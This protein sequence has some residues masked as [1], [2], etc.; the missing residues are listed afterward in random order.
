MWH[1]WDAPIIHKSGYFSQCVK[2]CLIM[3]LNDDFDNCNPFFLMDACGLWRRV[4]W[5]FSIFS[6]VH[7][8]LIQRECSLFRFKHVPSSWY[9]RTFFKIVGLLGGCLPGKRCSN[10]SC[11]CLILS[12]LIKFKTTNTRCSFVNYM[13]KMV[14]QR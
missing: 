13:I 1:I 3:R 8:V 11:N 2:S 5:T 14:L 4:I 9:L 6:V 12:G 10:E 7:M